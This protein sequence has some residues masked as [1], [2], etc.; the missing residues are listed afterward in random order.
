M[1]LWHPAT[2]ELPVCVC[3]QRHDAY[4]EIRPRHQLA[5]DVYYHP[6]SY[7]GGRD[8]RRG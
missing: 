2:D 1:L 5:L 8:N 6:Y 7:I 3:D 4:F